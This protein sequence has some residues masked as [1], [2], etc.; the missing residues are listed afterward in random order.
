MKRGRKRSLGI[1]LEILC[2][3]TGM[4]LKK[5]RAN[6]LRPLMDQLKRCADDDARRLLLKWSYPLN[7][8]KD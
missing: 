1:E 8:K 7:K 5:R 4:D 6:S 3:Q 2:E